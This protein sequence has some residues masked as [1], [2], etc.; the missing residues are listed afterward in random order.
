MDLSPIDRMILPGL[1]TSDERQTLYQTMCAVR[2][3][4]QQNAQT[5]KLQVIREA[6][7]VC[8]ISSTDQEQSRRFSQPQMME[9]MKRMDDTKKC[10][11]AKFCSHVALASGNSQKETMFLNWLYAEINVPNL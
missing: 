5:A 2:L 7:T 11:F 4:G 3:M 9:I 8:N 6:M 10:Y 1:F